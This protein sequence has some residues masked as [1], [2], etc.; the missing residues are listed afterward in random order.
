MKKP[1]VT[2]PILQ[3]GQICAFFD[4]E[5]FYYG[6]IVSVLDKAVQ[7]CSE[8]GDLLSF[9][10]ARLV[11]LS[12]A[13]YSTSDPGA[14]LAKF[15]DEVKHSLA[16]LSAET[17]WQQLKGSQ[18]ALS[19]QDIINLCG[20]R[21]TDTCQFALFTVLKEHPCLFRHKGDLYFVLSEEETIAAQSK[22][23]ERQQ[24]FEYKLAVEQWI[25]QIVAGTSPLS[26]LGNDLQSRLEREMSL[27][28]HTKPLHW[29]N[30][31]FHRVAP[32]QSYRD[33]LLLV[34]MALGQM[35]EQTDR[36]LAYSGLPV[37]FPVSV[38][39]AAK[40]IRPFLPDSAR[41]DLTELECWTIDAP[42]TEDIDDAISLQPTETGWELGIHISDVAHFVQPGSVVDIE[43]V[44]RTSS[45][46]LPDANV[47]M[48]PER[49]SCQLASLRAGET[50]PALSII[51]QIDADYKITTHKIVLAQIKVNRRFSYEE[52]E[53][54]LDPGSPGSDLNNRIS[55][56]QRIANIHLQ[57]R[58][59]RGARIVEDGTQSPARRLI[60]ELMVIYNSRMADFAKLHQLP[61]Y[62]RYLEE[63]IPE[64]NDRGFSDG[65]IF[66]PSVLGTRP[67]A[68]QAMG[69]DVYGQMTSP[70]RRYADL[71]N[72]RQVI[73]CL[74]KSKLLYKNEDLEK[75]IPH[76]LQ[77][78][79]TIRRVTYQSE[80]ESKLNN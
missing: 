18:Q 50:R 25:G 9:S 67:I 38:F 26:E 43:A 20:L 55:T 47:H 74:N 6:M 59:D 4:H 17:L 46:Y 30:Q 56:L 24:D 28:P 54:C 79:Q 77:T 35:D 13:V 75:L 1:P 58:I 52:F 64:Q 63:L 73:S 65:L 36:F 49:L 61:F 31:I 10:P 15:T 8:N 32:S 42:E 76:L 71:V 45:I 23:T 21:D 68:H 39:N 34:R 78:R 5:H 11:I 19:L 14:V 60:A 69:L 48:L 7:V 80:Q 72:Q 66:P 2:T 51:F 40:E 12:K 29:L 33:L 37:L 70:L 22:E 16:T 44:K 53:F 57:Q 62:Y 27:Q 3:P 41:L